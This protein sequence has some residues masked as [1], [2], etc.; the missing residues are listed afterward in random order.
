MQIEWLH[1]VK[2]CIADKRRIRYNGRDQNREKEQKCEAW[3]IKMIYSIVYDAVR[4]KA[5]T[6]PPNA[7]IANTEMAAAMGIILKELKIQQDSLKA[8]TPE[9][10]YE[11]FFEKIAGKETETMSDASKILFEQIKRYKVRKMVNE[12][13]E[14]LLALVNGLGESDKAL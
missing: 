1:F 14:D 6:T 5:S 11:N 8:A 7:L 2:V 4:K 3:R 13:M 12:T 10:L 9:E